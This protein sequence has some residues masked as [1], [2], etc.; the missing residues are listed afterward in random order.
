MEN[1]DIAVIG[2]SLRFPGANDADTYWNNL[3]HAVCSLTRFSVDE[4]V[5]AGV[6]R[7]LA[8]SPNYVPVGGVLDC[9]D[10]FDA[11]FFGMTDA[12]AALTDPQHRL[13]LTCAA[14]ALENGGYNPTSY[15][16]RIGCFGGAGANLYAGP[17]I[18]SYFSK[19]VAPHAALLK[20]TNGLEGLDVI[21]AI[22][23]T[24]CARVRL[25]S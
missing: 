17:Q 1:L 9:T 15:T 19:H 20:N 10:Q 21:I 2:L 25:T 11:T 23:M 5:A 7:T 18:D 22:T 14:E 13:F 16:G 3:R 12:E 4:L 8:E 6:T 24:F